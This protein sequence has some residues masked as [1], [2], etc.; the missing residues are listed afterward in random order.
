MFLFWSDKPKREKHARTEE[1]N[2]E[3]MNSY[4]R[5]RREHLIAYKNGGSKSQTDNLLCRRHKEL[6]I[7]NFKVIPGEVVIVDYASLTNALFNFTT[8]V[9]GETT[10]RR[11]RDTETWW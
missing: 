5:K 1:H 10:G 9:S 6:K 3:V 7:K 4:Y 11:Q 2:L 8:E